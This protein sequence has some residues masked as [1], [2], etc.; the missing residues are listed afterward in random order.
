MVYVNS[1]RSDLAVSRAVKFSRNIFRISSVIPAM[2]MLSTSCSAQQTPVRPYDKLCEAQIGLVG[3]ATTYAY[4]HPGTSLKEI[5]DLISGLPKQEQTLAR[6]A[7]DEWGK[8]LMKEATGLQICE[9]SDG[10][11]SSCRPAN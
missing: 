1:R 5:P 8:S 3:N 9:R 4:T 10:N 2:A 6:K 11:S 7:C